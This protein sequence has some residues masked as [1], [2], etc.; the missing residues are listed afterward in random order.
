MNSIR[1]KR[2]GKNSNFPELEILVS[3]ILPLENVM[4]QIPNAFS[5]SGGFGLEGASLQVLSTW[6]RSSESHIIH[7]STKHPA[8][9]DS[10][11]SLC[12]H[13]FGLCA[14]RLADTILS[15]TK[16][17]V[18]IQTA[19]KPAIPIFEKL[20]REDYKNA[21]KGMYLAIPAIKAPAI[22]NSRD[23]EYDSPL[24]NNEQVVGSEK[25]LQITKMALA[26]V[27]PQSISTNPLDPK[28]LENISEIIRE[29]F[30]NTH[31]HARSDVNEHPYGKNFRGIIFNTIMLKRARVRELSSSGSSVLFFSEWIPS[32]EK[33]FK[34]LDITVVD[35]GP[36]YARRWH[37]LDKDNLS[38]DQEKEAIIQCFKKH[39]SSDYTDSSGS[40]LTNVLRD[41]KALR[42]WFRLRTG[43][44]LIE[45]SF[46]DQSGTSAIELNDI[47]EMDTFMEGVT[48]NFIIPLAT[49]TRK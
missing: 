4:L 35:S 42:G 39:R 32:G 10:F 22:K 3:E 5:F 49:L 19:L 38:L 23:R 40:G 21:F 29:L 6:L 20:R 44:T 15:A 9:S 41:I 37:R 17:E 45:K 47:R 28:L 24:Y 43:R 7:T 11:E 33:T 31:R 25:F 2:I 27:L 8:Q 1:T 34:A 18:P 13:L 12:N 36:G 46:F 14:L 30:T 26:S 16:T 48:F